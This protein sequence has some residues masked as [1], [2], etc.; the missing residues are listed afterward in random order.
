MPKKPSAKSRPVPRGKFTSNDIVALA[1]ARGLPLTKNHITDRL[2]LIRKGKRSRPEGLKQDMSS[3][4][5]R[6][7]FPKAFV[8]QLLAEARQRKNLPRHLE[9]ARVL[10]LEKLASELGL[11]QNA[12]LRYH[13]TGK[14]NTFLFSGKHYV[15]RRESNRF[16]EWY[17]DNIAATMSSKG[18][19]ARLQGKRA[20]RKFDPRTQREVKWWLEDML[21]M[22]RSQAKAKIMR[23][24]IE[25]SRHVSYEEF[26]ARI[27]PKLNKMFKGKK[28]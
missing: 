14:L 1:K 9:K 18:G 12:I 23:K 4:G 28:G 26:M 15:T 2:R 5:Q 11:K 6:F 13:Y 17:N 3:V 27:S 19:K 24:L 21:P 8:N 16:K 22:V 25:G 7:L 20:R 10:P